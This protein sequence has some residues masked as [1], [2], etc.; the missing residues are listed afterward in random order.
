MD[1]PVAALLAVTEVLGY[2][3]YR[4]VIATK[5]ATRP[6]CHRDEGSDPWTATS[7]RSSQ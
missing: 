3:C 4:P 1:C 5:E 2:I 6:S 7:L